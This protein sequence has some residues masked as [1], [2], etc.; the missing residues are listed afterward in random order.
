MEPFNPIKIATAKAA[1]AADADPP[2]F[3][4]QRHL[5]DGMPDPGKGKAVFYWM[6]MGD[7]RSESRS[8]Y[9][10]QVVTSTIS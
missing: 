5:Q 2:Y 7:L 1:A 6:R 9:V 4:L 3:R 10:D 8:F